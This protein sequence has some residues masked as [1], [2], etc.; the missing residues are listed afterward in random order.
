[1]TASYLELTPKG[2]VVAGA[3]E[4]PVQPIGRPAISMPDRN[5]SDQAFLGQVA[6]P[7]VVLVRL[8]SGER[9]L[10]SMAPVEYDGDSLA[11]LAAFDDPAPT[12]IEEL[13][14][15]GQ[16]VAQIPIQPLP[17]S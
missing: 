7:S 13:N 14:S 5:R 16:V 8:V 1:V 4:K 2:V 17:R 6:D 12:S 10:D 15:E 11:V 9:V 3:S